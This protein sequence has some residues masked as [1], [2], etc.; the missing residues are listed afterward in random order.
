MNAASP[1]PA[2][3]EALRADPGVMRRWTRYKSMYLI[4]FTTMLADRVRAIRGP[5]VRTARN[6]YAEPILNPESEAWFAQNLDDFLK[7]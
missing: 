7:A 1:L 6:I 2:S 3:I 5:Y 4:D